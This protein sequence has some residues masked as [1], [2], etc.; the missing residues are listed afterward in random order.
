M[1][2][3]VA[4]TLTVALGAV[5]AACVTAE[6]RVEQAQK[7]E[8]QGR[9]EKAANL[10]IDALR[11]DANYPGARQ[12][13]LASGRKA[14][15]G[16]LKLATEFE[17]ANRDAQ[18]IDEYDKADRLA[19]SA[20]SVSVVLE[21]PSN[22]K[23][24]RDAAFTRALDEALKDAD[25]LVEAGR[26]E[27][28]AAAFANAGKR[29]DPR[30][31]QSGRIRASR[32][33]ALGSASEQAL[34]AG[35][36]ER[37]RSFA[38][39][40]VAVY[41]ASSV[42]SK[43]ALALRAR[44]DAGLYAALLVE[45]AALQ[46][47]GRFQAAY[48][49]VQRAL[50]VYGPEE[51]ESDAARVLRDTVIEQG[52]IHV[53][54]APVW[55]HDELAQGVPA[56]LLDEINDVLAEKHWNAPPLFVGMLDGRTVRTELRGLGLDRKNLGD[57]QARAVGKVLDADFVV[58][59]SLCGCARDKDATP[60]NL[61][62]ATKDGKGAMI[63]VHGARTLSVVCAYRIVRV[64]D[65]RAIAEG[66]ID[67]VARRKLR[68]ATYRGDMSQLLM[69]PDQNALFDARVI[70]AADRDL[71]RETAAGLANALAPVIYANLQR[72]LP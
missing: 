61:A 30:G 66:E 40:A 68:Y 33:S 60:R 65:G 28:A 17:E 59:T 46:G 38:D 27:E 9:W 10:Y 1:T 67:A 58:V 32:Y 7:A 47:E 5:L 29:F 14:I 13:L 12:G 41:G 55:R 45:T 57:R 72:H 35:E 24:R 69:T 42:Q 19:A 16:Y 31:T 51:A 22:Y 62:V 34:A 6:K 37:A 18:A 48:E 25:D 20:A 49:V 15:D 63:Q 64:S 54:A 23:T 21:L 2:R 52:T 11:R 70:A 56:G 26:Y 43:D 8:A 4:L 50:D 71:E 36:F 53:A 39:R 3:Y 44:V